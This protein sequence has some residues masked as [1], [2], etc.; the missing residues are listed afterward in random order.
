M[1]LGKPG[2]HFFFID[3]E[4]T[5][6]VEAEHPHRALPDAMWVWHQTVEALRK[7]GA[8]KVRP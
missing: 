8:L 4:A 5:G 6:V 7:T 2:Q 3:F 1:K